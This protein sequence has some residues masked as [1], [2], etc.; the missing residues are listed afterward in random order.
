MVVLHRHTGEAGQVPDLPVA[1]RRHSSTDTRLSAPCH[2][3][4]RAKWHVNTTT[5]RE[6]PAGRVAQK[7]TP[8]GRTVQ[9]RCLGFMCLD[10]D[11]SPPKLGG[12]PSRSEGGAVCSKARSATLWIAK[13]SLLQSVRF[14]EIYKEPASRTL[15]RPPQPSLR[16]GIPA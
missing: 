6:E 16:E 3:E 13:R 9:A 15:N 12:V 14:A 7:R 11:H 5:T 4:C 2:R 10:V 1:R 8:V